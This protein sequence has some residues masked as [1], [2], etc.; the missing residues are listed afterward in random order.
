MEEKKRLTATK[1]AIA[2]FREEHPSFTDEYLASSV[3]SIYPNLY[4][5]NLEV[6]MEIIKELYR[7]QD[8][9]TDATFS[10]LLCEM[11]E[12]RKL[13]RYGIAERKH[14]KVIAK[15]NPFIERLYKEAQERTIYLS[16]C[17]EYQDPEVKQY[18]NEVYSDKG[19]TLAQKFFTLLNNRALYDT[20]QISGFVLPFHCYTEP[21][22]DIVFTK[23]KRT[24]D[25]YDTDGSPLKSES[26]IEKK[27]EILKLYVHNSNNGGCLSII[28]ALITA[29]SILF[30][31]FKS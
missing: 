31:V 24:R 22:G 5:D 2:K 30:N 29:S 14:A 21:N 8:D 28:I 25:D 11:T 1:A 19:K 13:V 18:F 10:S 6:A 7:R 9:W 26:E 17:P 15:V 20:D 27:N 4:E 3:E 16:E 12:G 23:N